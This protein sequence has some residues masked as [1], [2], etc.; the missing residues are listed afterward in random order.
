MEPQYPGFGRRY[1]WNF[2]DQEGLEL[3]E[4]GLLGKIRPKE[5]PKAANLGNPSNAENNGS[6][7]RTQAGWESD[8]HAPTGTSP[9]KSAAI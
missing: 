6:H 9:A 1:L 3:H 5:C 7:G 4:P 8:E 2:Y